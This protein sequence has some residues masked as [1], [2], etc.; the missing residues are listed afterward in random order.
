MD[1]AVIILL[2]TWVF[3]AVLLIIQPWFS[4][5]NVLFGVVFATDAVWK[6]E[7]AKKIRMQYLL[8]MTVGTVLV[9]L[10]VFAWCL[11]G[12]M[13]VA[14]SVVPY[15]V[16]IGVLLVYGMVIFMV[17]HAKTMELKAENG[18]DSGLI[19]DRISVETSASDS[20]TVVSAAWLWL[21]LPVMLAVWAIAVFGYP[22]MPDKIPMHY[23]FTAVDA[24]TTKSWPMVLFPAL[25][26]TAVAVLI[27]VCC[28][29]TRRAP[30]SVRGN[31]DAAPKA[32][33]FRKYLILLMIV[34]GVLTEATFLLV[35]AGYLAPLSPLLFEVPLLLDLAVT[36]G[37]F[38]IYFR[39]VRVGKPKG[40]IMD[41]D[42]KWVLGMFYYN[43]SDPSTFIEKRTG[44]GYTLNF[45]RPGG[46]ILLIGV[47]AFVVLTIVFSYRS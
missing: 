6:D 25:T 27:L 13:S 40:P 29:F 4:R 34:L 18:D 42:A 47:L 36:V 32:F 11:M 24:W 43:P 22:S 14:A 26:G 17:Y 16:G 31:P 33:R 46:W 37:L 7:R 8:V 20:K 12:E 23:S 10:G 35:E 15:L 2:A 30:A 44:I 28:L 9:S 39:F 19:H 1:A 5:R 45:A 21:L 3:I 38:V 41:D